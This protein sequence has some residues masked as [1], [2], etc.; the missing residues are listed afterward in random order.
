MTIPVSLIEEAISWRRAFHAQ[1]ELGYQEHV[2]SRRV[3]ELLHSF[4]LQVH[5]GLAGTGVVGA[6]KN[7]P[8]PTIGFR[9]DMDALPITERSDAP[10]RSSQPGVMHAC[11]H[12]GHMAMLLAAARHLTTTRCF[13]STLQFVFQPAE[14]NLGGAQKMV[15]DSLFERFPMDA[16]YGIHN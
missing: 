10:W 9:A 15:A 4:G 12:D 1:P 16:I 5:T 3:A 7:G 8:A 2:T 6:L 11:G 14:E 13:S